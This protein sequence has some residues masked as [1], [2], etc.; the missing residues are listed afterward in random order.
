[1]APEEPSTPS[2]GRYGHI[3]PSDNPGLIKPVSY[4]HIRL[5]ALEHSTPLSWGLIRTAKMAKPI[6][7]LLGTAMSPGDYVRV[8]RT[9]LEVFKAGH[10]P[11]HCTPS[12]GSSAEVNAQS[13]DEIVV[14][15]KEDPQAHPSESHLLRSR[16]DST[17]RPLSRSVTVYHQHPP[18]SPLSKQVSTSSLRTPPPR[19][20]KCGTES[21]P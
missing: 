8:T 10:L 18:W 9:F 16:D 2:L 11:D 21:T 6:Y 5:M 13:Q 7:A 14:K 20:T 19:S 17:R 15:L 12:M 1:M 4:D 3:P